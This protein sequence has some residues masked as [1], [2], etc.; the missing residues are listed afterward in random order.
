MAQFSHLLLCITK[1]LRVIV[2]LF[3]FW[4]FN[5]VFISLVVLLGWHLTR[6]VIL[7]TVFF[8]VNLITLLFW[9]LF[10]GATLEKFGLSCFIL[11][12]LFSHAS[13]EQSF[14][15][16]S[17]SIRPTLDRGDLRFRSFLSEINRGLFTI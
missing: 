3:I 8:L 16:C 6:V 17:G 1:L 7:S 5:R 13:R 11:F 9:N 12:F 10:I 2:I 4:H 14:T 15:V